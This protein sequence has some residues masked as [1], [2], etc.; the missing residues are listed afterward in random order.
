M[1]EQ[2][3]RSGFIAIVGRPNVGKSTLMNRLVGQKVS[4]TSRKAQTTR[5]RINGILTRPD[6]QFVFVDTPGFQTSFGGALNRA[7]NHS[8]TDSLG[9]VDVAVLVVEAGRFSEHDAA[10][11][12]LV[13]LRHPV[14]L[15]INKIDRLA[16]KAALLPF[17]ERVRGKR[18]FVAVVPLSAETG[19]QCDVLLDTLAGLLPVGPS[20]FDEDQITDRSERF[21]AAEI[22]REKIF[23]QTGEEIPY[24]ANVTVETFETEGD[25]RRIGC[26]I[27]VARA[28]HKPMII[29]ARGARLKTIATEARM[30]MERLFEGKVFLELWVKVDENW[31]DD[32]KALRK[33]GYG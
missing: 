21:L 4:I 33:Y 22:V 27:V 7:L 25:M 10:V 3:H 32:P 11:L 13:P 31:S 8:V 17:I 18:D 24:G 5:H 19:L 6:A 9:S 30:D 14:V 20:M 12:R 15:A 16:D 29:G 2:P 28:N 23:R 26:L 1:S